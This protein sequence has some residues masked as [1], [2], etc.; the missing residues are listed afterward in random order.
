MGGLDTLTKM[1][2]IECDAEDR[3]QTE[4]KILEVQVFVN[5]FD[6]VVEMV[7]MWYS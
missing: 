7:S 4:I 6:E 5:P 3:P 1:E 2:V